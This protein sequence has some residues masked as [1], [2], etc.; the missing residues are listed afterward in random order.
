[1]D[2]ELNSKKENKAKV[3]FNRLVEK[4]DKKMKEKTKKSPCSCGPKDGN[5]SCRS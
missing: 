5:N 1:M 4:I 3:F 2:K